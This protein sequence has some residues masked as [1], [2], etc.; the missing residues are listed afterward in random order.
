VSDRAQTALPSMLR[1]RL[2]GQGH[3]AYAQCYSTYR[4]I[5][6]FITVQNWHQNPTAIARKTRRNR[7]AVPVPDDGVIHRH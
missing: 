4:T 5:L 6:R 2:K 1:P 7:Y 3:I